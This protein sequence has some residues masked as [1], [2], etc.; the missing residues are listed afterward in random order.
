MVSGV[1]LRTEQQP[2][3]IEL[4]TNVTAN[5]ILDRLLRNGAT[6]FTGVPITAAAFSNSWFPTVD[7]LRNFFSDSKDGMLNLLQPLEAF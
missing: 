2:S 7:N 3:R 5:I 4:Q 1:F 6:F